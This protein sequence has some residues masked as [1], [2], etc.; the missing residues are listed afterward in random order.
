MDYEYVDI[1]LERK[2]QD[3]IIINVWMSLFL[4]TQMKCIYEHAT[5]PGKVGR[6][7]LG[8]VLNS[9]PVHTNRNG[10][11]WLVPRALGE[12][13]GPKVMSAQLSIS[14]L[15]RGR[16]ESYE[17]PL[18]IRISRVGSDWHVFSIT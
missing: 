2:D 14:H 4:L 15:S 10:N 1:A 13:R 16:D 12:I 9:R 11:G 3:I 8:D 7:G 18:E 5:G 6:V 17:I